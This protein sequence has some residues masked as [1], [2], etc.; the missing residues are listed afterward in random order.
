MRGTTTLTL[1]L[2]VLLAACGGGESASSDGT[3]GAEDTAA[4][5]DRSAATSAWTAR[6]DEGATGLAAVSFEIVGGAIRLRPGPRAIYWREG[7]GASVPFRVRATFEMVSVPGRPE[8]Y[9]LFVGGRDLE[10][11]SQDYLYFLV[12][13][14]GRYLLKHRAGDETHTLVE[15]SD[16]PAVRSREDAGGPP[17]NALSVVAGEGRLLFRANGQ[18]VDSLPLAE[19]MVRADGIAGLRVNHGLDLRVR[20]FGVESG[21]QPGG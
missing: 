16:H 3:A 11:P 17:T 1:T 10:G 20:G 13:H 9:G 15:W 2:T 19:S 18:D 14:D 12:R 6:T 4:M 5:P 8:A 21:G 7:D